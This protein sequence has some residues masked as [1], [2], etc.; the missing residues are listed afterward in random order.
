[1]RFIYDDEIDIVGKQLSKEIVR[2]V[3]GA[4]R[5]KIRDDDIGADELISSDVADRAVRTVER[6]HVWRATSGDEQPVR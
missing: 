5:V 4:K 6:L 3:T 1:V 2:I